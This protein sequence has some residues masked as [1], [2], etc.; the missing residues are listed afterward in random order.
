LLDA[1]RA[2][3]GLGHWWWEHKIERCV[4]VVG[5]FLKGL[6]IYLPMILQFHSSLFTPENENICPW[7][8]LNKNVSR[9]FIYNS[10]K[11]WMTNIPNKMKMI[12]CINACNKIILS[13]INTNGKNAIRLVN[14]QNILAKWK[15]LRIFKI[16][17]QWF[18]LYE[19][20][21]DAKLT[22]DYSNGS[23]CFLWEQ[24][25]WH[26]R[27]KEIFRVIKMFCVFIQMFLMQV[28]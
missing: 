16:F 17:I 2:S 20:K 8:A 3:P 5:Q 22:C 4:S 27:A 18:Y 15:R 23:N 9:R 14:P 7:K 1:H 12:D 24:E 26:G 6:S 19:V 28:Y 10:S 13:F 21:G 25:E 11:I